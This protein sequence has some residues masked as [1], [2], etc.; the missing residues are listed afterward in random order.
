MYSTNL[1]WSAA[2]RAAAAARSELA[3]DGGARVGEDAHRAVVDDRLALGGQLLEVLTVDQF[4][5]GAVGAL[6]VGVDLHNGRFGSVAGHDDAAVLLE[7]L[8]GERPLVL[9]GGGSVDACTI[10]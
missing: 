3:A 1:P 4:E 8:G 7:G 5:P 6:V 2:A 10:R 9:L